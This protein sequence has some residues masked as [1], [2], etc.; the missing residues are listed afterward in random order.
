[1]KP[2]TSSNFFGGVVIALLVAVPFLVVVAPISP[3][4][5]VNRGS[6]QALQADTPTPGPGDTINNY[7]GITCGDS[8]TPCHV[9]ID[10]IVGITSTSAL[11]ITSTQPLPVAALTPLPITATIPISTVVYPRPIAEDDGTVLVWLLAFILSK[12]LLLMLFHIPKGQNAFSGIH[13]LLVTF[14]FL[15]LD[16]IVLYPATQRGLGYQGYGICLAAWLIV[17]FYR[18]FLEMLTGLTERH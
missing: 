17:I 13:D 16:I 18:D 8:G 2:A 1:M 4:S 3:V 11:W 14:A 9:V 12:F 10:N 15:G 6:S 5:A 7:Y